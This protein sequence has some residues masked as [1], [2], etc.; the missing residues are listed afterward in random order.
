M[1]KTQLSTLLKS[2]GVPVNEGITSRENLNKWPRI[3]YS[4]YIE[5]DISAS[6]GDYANQQTYQVDF[7]SKTPENEKFKALRNRLRKEG[8]FPVIY[9]EYVER[10]PVYS[11]CWH[12]YFSVDVVDDTEQEENPEGKG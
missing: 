1:T 2:A 11:K 8:I 4:C 5:Q 10:D 6:G 12:T 3:V 7:F 9:H